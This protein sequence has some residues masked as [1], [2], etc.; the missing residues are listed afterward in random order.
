M[1]TLKEFI[2]SVLQKENIKGDVDKIAKEIE[3]EARK[4]AVHGIACICDEEVREMT[5][6]IA[7]LM[8]KNPDAYKDDKSKKET[9]VVEETVDDEEVVEEVKEEPKK[10]ENK[11]KDKPKEEVKKVKEVKVEEPKEDE[12]L[13][14]IEKGTF[15]KEMIVINVEQESLF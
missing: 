15:G 8:L 12:K 5:I 3:K 6:N 1:P 10:V 7:D 11:V 13:K 2:R 9:K 14:K 4:Q